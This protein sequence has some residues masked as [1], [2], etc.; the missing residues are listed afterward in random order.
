VI[1]C[2]TI[3]EEQGITEIKKLGFVSTIQRERV[4]TDEERS[5]QYLMNGKAT[6]I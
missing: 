5:K 4:T 6:N 1:A 3:E 2:S